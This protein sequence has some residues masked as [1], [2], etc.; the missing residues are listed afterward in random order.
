MT[1]IE[2]NSLRFLDT[3]VS[4]NIYGFSTSLFRKIFAVLFPPPS[5]P[6]LPFPRS[7]II[8]FYTYVNRVINICSNQATFNS[9]LQYDKAVVIDRGCNPSIIDKA[10]TKL[11]Q[12]SLKIILILKS[13]FF[14]NFPLN[15]AF[16]L[17]RFLNKFLFKF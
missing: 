13:M 15:I 2:N 17:P 5:Y 12:I 10:F 16:L 7:K 14:N 4:S 11:S 1:N 8:A 9:E 3:L 6:L